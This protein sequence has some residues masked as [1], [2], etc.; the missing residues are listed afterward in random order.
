[1]SALICGSKAF[2]PVA[3]NASAKEDFTSQVP[4]VVQLND[5]QQTLLKPQTYGELDMGSLQQDA[6]LSEQMCNCEGKHITSKTPIRLLSMW[7]FC[8]HVVCW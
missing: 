6:K 8:L 2:R 4:F 5:M 7:T 1:M 3:R